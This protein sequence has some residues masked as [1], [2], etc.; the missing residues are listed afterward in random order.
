MK[1]NWILLGYLY[2][3]FQR[4]PVMKNS[5]KNLYKPITL[6][7]VRGL[8]WC[9]HHFFSLVVSIFANFL[10]IFIHS[11][12]VLVFGLW[13]DIWFRPKVKNIPSVIH[14]LVWMPREIQILNWNYYMC[15]KTLYWDLCFRY[16]LRR[17]LR[18]SCL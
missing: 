5:W 8:C 14:C 15:Y 12:S 6:H 3:N 11:A 17:F 10:H 4:I 13:P 16:P 7:T 18:I 1:P 2:K 9:K